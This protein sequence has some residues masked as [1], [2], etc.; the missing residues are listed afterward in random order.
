LGTF[1]EQRSLHDG[2]VL[3]RSQPGII[4]PNLIDR[5]AR[6]PNGEKTTTQT[7]KNHGEKPHPAP[8][9]RHR[10]PHRGRER[11]ATVF[12]KTTFGGLREGYTVDVYVETSLLKAYNPGLQLVELG[13][14][15]FVPILSDDPNSDSPGLLI[16]LFRLLD[17]S[18]RSIRVRGIPVRRQLALAHLFGPHA[19][20]F[21]REKVSVLFK[22]AAGPA[23]AK[24][25][26]NVSA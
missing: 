17:F 13:F 20:R 19:L 18:R 21:R 11:L 7:A 12:F 15:H 5:H 3:R 6:T 9:S 8:P 26:R 22:A 23:W 14:A 10:R 16:T 2:C 1:S 24:P 4:Q 25:Y